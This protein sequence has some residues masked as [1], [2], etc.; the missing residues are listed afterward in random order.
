[1]SSK[2]KFVRN[3]DVTAQFRKGWERLSYSGRYKMTQLKKAMLLLIAND[4]PLSPEYKDY[5]LQGE[6]ADQRDYH[7]GG[8]WL[9]PY[10]IRDAGTKKR[11]R[12]I[13]AN[14][15]TF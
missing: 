12:C 1:M 4:G 9:L 15:D 5:P 6:F 14:W 13:Y 2:V 8:D 3:F 7:I 11:N 10:T